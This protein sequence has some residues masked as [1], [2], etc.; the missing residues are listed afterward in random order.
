MSTQ[1]KNR[2]PHIAK[3]S[4]H[5]ASRAQMVQLFPQLAQLSD[6]QLRSL[7]F[8][9]DAVRACAAK[10]AMAADADGTFGAY[11]LNGWQIVAR[12]GIKRFYDQLA[13]LDA[14]STTFSDQYVVQGSPNVVPRLE[15]PLYD[16]TGTA[17]VDN[18][19]N[20]D[21]RASGAMS[22]AEVQLHKVDDVIEIYARDI[23]RGI[24]PQP[25][26]EAALSRVANTVQSQVFKALA[27]GAKQADNQ[28]KKVAGVQL[29]AIGS[30]NG[31]FNFGYANQVLSELIQ[32]RVS[33]LL[34]NSA[35][36]GA[37]KADNREAFSPHDVDVDLVAKVQGLEDLG[38][39]VVGLA[40]NK[41]GAALGM[42]APYMFPEAYNSFTQLS[43]EGRMSPISIATY[44]IPGM[45]CLKVWVGTYVGVS[46]TDADAVK[47]LIGFT[48]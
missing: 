14:I 21:D 8:N 38:S 31:Q 36:Y 32:P 41:R 22:S 23:E 6:G 17:A 44:F 10:P 40:V 25:L 16:N 18:Y 19:T 11:A 35:H 13:P 3:F 15:V 29:P 45:N 4:M 12:D 5:D 37:L 24:D 42:I 26:I 46:V 20:M 48:E 9:P 39:N 47:P 28:S 1:Q 43:Y 33:G 30:E 34:L 7:A 2:A 27:I